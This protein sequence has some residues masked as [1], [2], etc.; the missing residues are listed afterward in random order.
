MYLKKKKNLPEHKDFITAFAI[1]YGVVFFW[2][3][4]VD[5]VASLR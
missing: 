1:S 4:C 3:N 2:D 5:K